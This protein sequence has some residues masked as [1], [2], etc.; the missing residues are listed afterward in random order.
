MSAPPGPL[1]TVLESQGD[2]VGRAQ[3]PAQVLL[4]NTAL[5]GVIRVAHLVLGFPRVGVGWTGAPGAVP[6]SWDKAAG[7]CG[8]EPS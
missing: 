2:S 5:S 4:S 8:E 7:R 6:T 3:A 1:R